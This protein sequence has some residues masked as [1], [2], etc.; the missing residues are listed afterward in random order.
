LAKC[1]GHKGG[2]TSVAFHPQAKRLVTASM[3]GTVRQWDTETGQEVEPPFDSH[4]G[5]VTSA[6]YS[7][8]GKCIAST[9]TD[10]TTRIWSAKDLESLA[11]LHG[12]AGF[13]ANVVFA[14]SSRRLASQ[15]HSWISKPGQRTVAVWDMD[16]QA[17]LPKLRG[18]ARSVRAVAVSS[19][20]RWIASGSSDNSARLW[21]ATTGQSFATLPHPGS[22]VAIAFGPDGKSLITGN[23]GDDRLRIWDIETSR[24]VEEIQGLGSFR[25][26][27]LSPNGKEL[28]VSAFFEN[29]HHI[30]VYE[31]ASGH[32]LYSSEGRALAYSPDG[33]CMATVATDK[34][35][36]LHIYARTHHVV[37]RLE[38]HRGSLTSAAFSPDSRHVATTSLDG[39]IRLWLV[40]GGAH[41]ELRGNTNKS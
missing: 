8:D 22:V 26:L 18:H 27:I 39:T 33:Q 38:G 28:A 5:S 20:G 30:A 25:F 12:H 16:P 21:D 24:L 36:L 2:V 40:D 14:P 4:S 31:L 35:I 10:H 23:Q 6:V 29:K 37:D 32:K 1:S 17:P 11:V 3:D 13:P 41:H 15:S 34:N 9:G 19:D 7:P